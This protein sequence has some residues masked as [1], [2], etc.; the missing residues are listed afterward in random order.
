MTNCNA[1]QERHEVGAYEMFLTEARTMNPDDDK[2]CEAFIE[3][4][5]EAF[6]IDLLSSGMA[7]RICSI[8]CQRKNEHC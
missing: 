2:A 8:L 5:E 7:Q 4:V 6:N 1:I 3:R